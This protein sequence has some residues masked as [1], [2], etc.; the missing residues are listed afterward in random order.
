MLPLVV[1]LGRLRV[2]LV[3]NGESA[4]RRLRLLAEAGARTLALYA[5]TPSPA[6]AAAAGSRLVRRLPLAQELAAAHLV[7]IA[8]APPRLR[9]ALAETAR[10]GGALVHVEDTPLLSDLHA[11]AILRRGDLTIAVSTGGRSPALA[12]QVKRFLGRLFGP[13]WQERLDGLAKL[14][15]DWR[16]G[17]A[18]APTVARRTDQWIDGQGWLPVGDVT[19]TGSEMPAAE[20]ARALQATFAPT[21]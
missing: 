9:S 14:R 6:L 12:A 17:G 20:A 16:D 19:P 7:F 18:D 15:R 2:V 4:L 1:D 5:D 13:E 10:A 11:P 21:H 8:D 3:G